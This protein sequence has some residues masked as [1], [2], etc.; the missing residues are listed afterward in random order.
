[1]NTIKTDVAALELLAALPLEDGSRWGERAHPFQIS[2]ARAV[3]NPVGPRRHYLLRGRGMSKTS[4]VAAI[5]LVLLLTDAPAGSSSHVYAADEEQAALTME[6]LRG[7]IDR[8]QLSAQL[9]VSA[10]SV[11]STANAAQLVVETGDGA[12]ALGKRP[13]LTVVDELAAWPNTQNHRTLWSAIVSAVPKVPGSRLIVITTAGSPTGL[14]SKVWAEAEN[15][16]YWRT[17][18]NPGPSPWWSAEDVDATRSALSASEWRRL[19]LCEFAEGDDALSTPE[20]VQ[21]AIRGGSAVLPPQGSYEYVA[22]LDVGTRRD[23]TALAVGHLEEGDAGRTVI[24]DRV[25]SWR[26]KDGQGGRVDLAEVEAATLRICREYGA[27]LRF[28][29]M[30]AEQLTTNLAREGVRTEEFIFS[31]TGANRIAR[32]L[33]GA[34]RDRALSLPDDAELR[35]E[36]LTTRLVETGPG[37][38]KLQNPP[39]THDDIVTAVGMVVAD[40]IDKPTSAPGGIVMPGESVM[41]G[42]NDPALSVERQRAKAQMPLNAARSGK[43]H[44]DTVSRL[45]AAR[46]HRKRNVT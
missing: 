32:T 44:F 8:A 12:S 46:S 26:P 16:P 43:V 33:W 7:F 20:D 23:L 42:K 21:V 4:D 1:M 45:E 41:L 31:S 13:W 34:L 28:D 25:L 5:V 17:A 2:D 30:Q 14:G 36:F 22:A 10:R 29:R 15:S 37:V 9:R 11:T 6:A 38:V 35:E 27:K 18:K 19:I 40:I 3:L 39:G 24:I